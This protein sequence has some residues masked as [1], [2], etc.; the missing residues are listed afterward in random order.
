VNARHKLGQMLGKPLGDHSMQPVVFLTAEKAQPAPAL[1]ALAHESGT[2]GR[3]FAVANAFPI[4][5][6]DEG[7]VSIR[8]RRRLASFAKPAFNLLRRQ[9]CRM[10]GAQGSADNP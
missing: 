4:A 6:G 5:K 2:I 10:A 9:L 8:R 1:L 3:D 7:L